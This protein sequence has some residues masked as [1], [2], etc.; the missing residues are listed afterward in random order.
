MVF[1]DPLAYAAGLWHVKGAYL[2]FGRPKSAGS[3]ADLIGNGYNLLNSGS[4]RAG[5]HTDIGLYRSNHHG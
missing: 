3:L 1:E 5:D 4:L 2:V